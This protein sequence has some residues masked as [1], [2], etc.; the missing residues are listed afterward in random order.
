MVKIE[1]PQSRIESVAVAR[2]LVMGTQAIK[3]GDELKAPIELLDKNNKIVP[4]VTAEPIEVIVR[5]TLAPLVPRHNVLITPSW[6]GQPAFGF[7]IEGYT[8]VPN[9]VE[10][11][12]DS[13]KLSNIATIE[14][15]PIRIEGLNQDKSISVAL[16]IPQGLAIKGSKSVTVRIRVRPNPSQPPAQNEPP[17]P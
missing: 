11:T 8:L 17:G 14:T 12:G 16:R 10:L 6:I 5:P 2:A 3:P 9:Q 15:E 1:G 13:R 4:F 7:R